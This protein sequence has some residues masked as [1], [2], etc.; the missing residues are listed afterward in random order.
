MDKSKALKVATNC[1]K[2]EIKYL[3]AFEKATGRS[4]KAEIKKLKESLE[5]LKDLDSDNKGVE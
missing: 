5:V 2:K 1:I 4:S 3:Q